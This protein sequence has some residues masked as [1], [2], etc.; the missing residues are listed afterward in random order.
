MTFTGLIG[1]A[2]CHDGYLHVC[3]YASMSELI[4][5]LI[6][7][8]RVCDM[9]VCLFGSVTCPTNCCWLFGNFP[10]FFVDVLFVW[11]CSERLFLTS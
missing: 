10:V 2:V 11:L 9:F 1:K 6:S 4:F 8:L 7:Y 5:V 3:K